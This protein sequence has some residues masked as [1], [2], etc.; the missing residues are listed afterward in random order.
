[1]G[2]AGR[3]VIVAVGGTA[4]A[5]GDA[6]TAIVVTVAGAGVRAV[7]AVTNTQMINPAKPDLLHFIF[8]SF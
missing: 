3:L 7:Q 1:V 8:Y 4:A 6:S 5:V 2:S